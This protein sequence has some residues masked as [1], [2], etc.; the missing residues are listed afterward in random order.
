[1]TSAIFKI[2]RK[3][4]VAMHWLYQSILGLSHWQPL[5]CTLWV[6]PVFLSFYWILNLECDYKLQQ[7]QQ[8]EEKQLELWFFISDVLVNEQLMTDYCACVKIFIWIK[9]MLKCKIMVFENYGMWCFHC[10][11]LIKSMGSISDM[12]SLGFVHCW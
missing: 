5:W 11:L 6:Y 2:S 12:K 4:P 8:D 3:Q 9:I 1:M 7:P 10:C